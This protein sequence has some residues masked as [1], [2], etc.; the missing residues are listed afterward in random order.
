MKLKRIFIL[1]I[2]IMPILIGCVK[3]KNC[4]CGIEGTFVY[5]PATKSGEFYINDNLNYFIEGN[6]PKK[7][8]STTPINVR[9]CIVKT[10]SVQIFPGQGKF[11]CVEEIK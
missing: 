3:E 2:L 5:N 4:D 9:A 10:L 11:T 7:V 1:L 8:Q 6:I